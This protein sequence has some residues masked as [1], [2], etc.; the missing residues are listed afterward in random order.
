M[1]LREEMAQQQMNRD[2]A[3]IEQA[4]VRAREMTSKK[5]EQATRAIR[6]WR[7]QRSDARRG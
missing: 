7:V 6:G 5:R 4:A 2:K 1:G 3:E